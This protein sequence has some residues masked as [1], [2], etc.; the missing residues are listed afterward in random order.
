M[1]LTHEPLVAAPVAPSE[2]LPITITDVPCAR[3]HL[4]LA[5]ARK[6]KSERLILRLYADG[7]VCMETSAGQTDNAYISE[8][9]LAPGE[10]PL[11]TARHLKIEGSKHITYLSSLIPASGTVTIQLHG[12]AEEVYKWSERASEH[13]TQFVG[14]QVSFVL[15]RVTSTLYFEVWDEATRDLKDAQMCVLPQTTIP[16]IIAASVFTDKDPLNVTRNQVQV[17]VTDTQLHV[18]GTNAHV[19]LRATHAR[20][21]GLPSIPLR[22]CDTMCKMLEART[23]GRNTPPALYAQKNDTALR[24]WTQPGTGSF[25]Q[26]DE[27]DVTWQIPHNVFPDAKVMKTDLVLRVPVKTLRKALTKA[28]SYSN[29]YTN[30]VRLRFAE[31]AKGVL[32]L[33]ACDPDFQNK[34]TN[35]LEVTVTQHPKA[36]KG[37]NVGVNGRLGMQILKTF[38]D[39]D[40]VELSIGTP[41]RSIVVRNTNAPH[42]DHLWMPVMISEN[43]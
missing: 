13:E 15:P 28:M 4:F 36:Y 19:L 39:K 11:G 14:H 30:L 32:L 6:V 41:D 38:G 42:V 3:I 2:T 9:L 40:T 34:S 16:D 17:Q 31:I 8:Q 12:L 20:V 37:D 25:M 23:T 22:I 43:F 1:T 7:Y 29:S 21:E 10:G 33:E 5:T 35:K 18:M 26:T 27:R 24:V